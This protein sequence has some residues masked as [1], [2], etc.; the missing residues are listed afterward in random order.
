MSSKRAYDWSVFERVTRLGLV[1]KW[2]AEEYY[3]ADFLITAVEPHAKGALAIDPVT[4]EP[5]ACD[6][7]PWKGPDVCNIGLLTSGDFWVLDIDGAQGERSLAWLVKHVLT[8]DV[9]GEPMAW[10]SIDATVKTPNGRHIYFWTP[11]GCKIPNTVG[12]LPGIDV[13]GHGGQVLV[14]G[15]INNNGQGYAVPLDTSAPFEP[16]FTDALKDLVMNATPIILRPRYNDPSYDA[17]AVARRAQGASSSKRT[18]TGRPIITITG[19]PKPAVNYDAPPPLGDDD[20]A[21]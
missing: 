21:F 18:L 10:H 20:I 2:A 1:G 15:S 3:K 11:R 17:E 7:D 19:S 5:L 13:R 14:P 4:F 16:M 9:F 8:R 6:L 12:L